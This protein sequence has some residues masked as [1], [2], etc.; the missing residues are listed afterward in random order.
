MSRSWGGG[1]R[2]IVGRKSA[3]VTLGIVIGA[4]LV[5]QGAALAVRG[6]QSVFV[7]NDAENAVPTREQNVDAD[8]NVEVSDASTRTAVRYEGNS[9]EV[10]VPE[11][12]EGK[13][14]LISYVNVDGGSGVSGTE[15]TAAS[16]HLL[17]RRPIDDGGTS[18]G[19]FAGLPVVLSGTETI[20]VSESMSLPLHAGEALLF[21]CGITP[22][23]ESGFF[24]IKVVGHYVPAT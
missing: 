13:T 11:V 18:T 14:F 10:I 17:R 24:R 21:S 5:P 7:A 23:P 6:M 20:A 4:L 1:A 12:P 16:C 15:V 19:A 3:L 22:R 9:S 2:R 8:G